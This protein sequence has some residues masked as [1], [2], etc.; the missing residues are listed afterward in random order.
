MQGRHESQLG[1]HRGVVDPLLIGQG[2]HSSRRVQGT[3]KR[4]VVHSLK[5]KMNWRQRL[6]ISAANDTPTTSGGSSDDW[7]VRE[8]GNLLSKAQVWQESDTRAIAALISRAKK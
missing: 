1:D 5:S 7:L 4:E 3:M 6:M 8:V 2:Y